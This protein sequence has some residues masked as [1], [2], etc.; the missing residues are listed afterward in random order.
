MTGRPP[1][2]HY[3]TCLH[4]DGDN[5]VA[6]PTFVELCPPTLLGASAVYIFAKKKKLSAVGMEFKDQG[7]YSPSRHFFHAFSPHHLGIKSVGM[8]YPVVLTKP[9]LE[10]SVPGW[11]F[12]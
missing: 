11:G 7:Y 9:P 5:N 8:T 4:F 2:P 12:D 6:F 10:S 3:G 1:P